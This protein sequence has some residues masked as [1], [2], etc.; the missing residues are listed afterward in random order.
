MQKGQ[1]GKY[2]WCCRSYAWCDGRWTA[3]LAVSQAI[4]IMKMR[5]N[6]KQVVSPGHTDQHVLE[7]SPPNSIMY[8]IAW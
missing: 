3:S 1:L 6:R 8:S 5:L 4:S 7:L 2:S